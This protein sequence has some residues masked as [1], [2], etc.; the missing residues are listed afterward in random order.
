MVSFYH[1]YSEYDDVYSSYLNIQFASYRWN[2]K[3][4]LVEYHGIKREERLLKGEHSGKTTITRYLILK[5]CL[6]YFVLYEKGFNISSSLGSSFSKV[7]PI[8]FMK[9][10]VHTLSILEYIHVSDSL[11][12][13]LR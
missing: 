12:N 2:K 8:H 1:S 11:R 10:F 3:I 5:R 9:K 13:R 4:L 7:I 6:T